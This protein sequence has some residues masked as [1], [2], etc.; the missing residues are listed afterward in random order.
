MHGG[1]GL[2]GQLGIAQS[3]VPPPPQFDR[4]EQRKEEQ[5]QKRA[6]LL[7]KI[8]PYFDESDEE[9]MHEAM[10]RTKATVSARRH[11]TYN[12]LQTAATP[13]YIKTFFKNPMKY[14]ACGAYSSFSIFT[15]G[16]LYG[17]NLVNWTW[18]G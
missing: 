7:Q 18:K 14:I 10:K 8:Q 11:V 12:P 15:T 5:L 9:E 3:T 13:K 4:K 16:A 1:R 6:Q 2:E 17:P